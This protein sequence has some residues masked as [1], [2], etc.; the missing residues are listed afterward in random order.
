MAQNTAASPVSSAI[1][2]PT[3]RPPQRDM[4]G[5]F[6]ALRTFARVSP[7]KERELAERAATGD[8][9]AR[10]RLVEANL[11]LVVAIAR[12]YASQQVPLMDLIQEGNLGLLHAIEKFDWRRGYAFST[13]A[14]WWIRQ[15]ISRA[16]RKQMHLIHIPENLLTASRH[17]DLRRLLSPVDAQ[18]L[19]QPVLSLDVPLDVDER[20][21][22]TDTLEDRDAVL[23]EAAVEQH[24][25]SEDLACALDTLTLR[26]RQVLCLH[27]GID[28]GI[29]HTLGQIGKQLGI[30]RERVRQIESEALAMLRD[31]FQAKTA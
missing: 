30:S 7:E 4:T 22:L 29:P 11:R 14:T 24:M 16:L 1:R 3:S 25:V 26:Q 8:R 12:Q 21:S 28:T 23:P 31:A 6:S 17:S 27:F 9:Q 5:Y 19:L 13:Y 18:M 20:L 2:K 10:D 15:A